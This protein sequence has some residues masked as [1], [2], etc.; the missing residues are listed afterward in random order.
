VSSMCLMI[1]PGGK[2]ELKLD[3]KPEAEVLGLSQADLGRQVRAAFYGA[4]AQRVQRGREDV[5]VMVRYP[6]KD[7]R[8]IAVLEDMRIRTE[9]GNEVPFYEVSNIAM[10]R[11]P[12]TISRVD[13]NRAIRIVA[14]L[15]RSQGDLWQIKE[16]LST[17][18][19]PALMDKY[20]GSVWEFKGEIGEGMDSMS[21]LLSGAIIVLCVIYILMAIPFKSYIQPLIIMSAI[22]FG[23]IGAVFGHVIFGQDISILSLTG[24]LAMAGVLVNDSLV[25]VDYINKQVR[26]G[27]PEGE[28]VRE[29][30]VARFRPIILTS[31]TTFAGLS[32]ILLERSLQ[33]QF[34]IPMAI[35]L[36]F[37]V[38]FGTFITLLLVPS[39]YLILED[40]KSGILK[41]F[42]YEKVKF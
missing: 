37:G 38:L 7:R 23:L 12:S 36:A 42:A 16:K 5:R 21:S 9:D 33:A 25:M 20:P 3:I 31:L 14:N 28:A 10:G 30:G 19:M 22:P 2:R 4:E 26:S 8:N 6:E 29:A 17:E 18:I 32:P 34:L 13:R 24:M 1:I 39:C 15:D 11:G 40:I 27:C 35:S 41:I